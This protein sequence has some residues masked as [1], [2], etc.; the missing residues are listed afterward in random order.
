MSILSAADEAVAALVVRQ[1][2]TSLSGGHPR[3]FDEQLDPAV[4]AVDYVKGI[5]S[6]LL[7]SFP[8]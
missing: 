1:S 3:F 4:G 8:P 6:G 5:G 2:N 7:T